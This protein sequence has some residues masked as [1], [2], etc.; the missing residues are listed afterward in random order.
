MVTEWQVWQVRGTQGL[1]LSSSRLKECSSDQ[2]LRGNNFLIE[3]RGRGY[4]LIVPHFA[5]ETAFWETL[6]HI[7]G[8]VKHM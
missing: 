6:W 2:R 8:S 1:K 7:I 5:I 4:F 3:L